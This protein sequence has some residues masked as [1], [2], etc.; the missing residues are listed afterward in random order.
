MHFTEG[1]GTTGAES[2]GIWSHLDSSSPGDNCDYKLL[3]IVIIFVGYCEYLVRAFRFYVPHKSIYMCFI[4]VGCA[5]LT[6][7][8]IFK[9]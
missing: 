2:C 7:I 1:L 9:I 3:Y 4:F 5:E 8:E 6:W